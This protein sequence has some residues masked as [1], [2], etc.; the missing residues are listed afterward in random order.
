MNNKHEIKKKSKL[1]PLATPKQ[2]AKARSPIELWEYFW[3]FWLRAEDPF[4]VLEQINDMPISLICSG[5][6][7]YPPR[8]MWTIYLPI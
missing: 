5:I 8:S 2:M 7:E 3:G 1:A 4:E 6:R